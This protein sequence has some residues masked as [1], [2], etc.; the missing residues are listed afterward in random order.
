MIMGL[1]SGL[2]E[3]CLSHVGPTPVVGRWTHLTAASLEII[4][5]DLDIPA[6]IQE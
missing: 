1:E 6:G 3:P 2:S 5:L 4:R